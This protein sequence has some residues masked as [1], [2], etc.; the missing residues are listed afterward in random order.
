VLAQLSSSFSE[1]SFSISVF[2]L[3]DVEV[4]PII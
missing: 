2:S 1:T 3:Q 4:T